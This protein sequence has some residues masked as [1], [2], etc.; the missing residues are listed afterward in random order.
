MVINVSMNK[1]LD[2]SV[3]VKQLFMFKKIHTSQNEYT[4]M[5]IDFDYKGFQKSWTLQ[6]EMDTYWYV[7]TLTLIMKVF[8]N[9]LVVYV[10]EVTNIIL[11]LFIYLFFLRKD[12]KRKKKYQT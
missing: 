4:Q 11:N 2:D 6:I 7:E 10:I 1:T 3:I 8:T 9:H 12:F 5:R